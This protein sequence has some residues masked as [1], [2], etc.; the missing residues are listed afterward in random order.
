MPTPLTAKN[1]GELST[2][3]QLLALISLGIPA[4]GL[5]YCFTKHREIHFDNPAWNLA[6]H[7]G[8]L[9]FPL[10]WLWLFYSKPVVYE[11]SDSEIMLDRSSFFSCLRFSWWS[12]FMMW[13]TPVFGVIAVGEAFHTRYLEDPQ[14]LST[15]PGKAI[16]IMAVIFCLGMFYATILLNR[17]DPA[18]WISNEGMRTSIL[19]F[20][21]WEDIHHLTQRGNLYAI[22]H[23]V[24]PA[25]PAASF[26]VRT[27][28]SQAILERHLMEHHVQISN[29]SDPAY[30]LVQMAVILGFAANLAADFWLRWNTALPLTWMIL[31]SF[32]IGIV[33]TILLEKY[34]GVSKYGKYKPVINL[35]EPPL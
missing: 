21:K 28:E 6:A 4:A 18:T 13:A 20:H 10:L 7:A 33:L 35:D 15:S 27:P 8:L 29:A 2:G 24:N 9:V 11:S 23:R 3:D 34:R 1:S 12:M 16:F 32:S 17:S 31:I 25:L 14:D 5:W 19:R 26:R 22:H 30:L